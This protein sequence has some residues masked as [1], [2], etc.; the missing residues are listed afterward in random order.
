MA[1]T[2]WANP[3]MTETHEITMAAVRNFTATVNWTLRLT[4]RSSAINEIKNF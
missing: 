3:N 1:V 2:P 4:S